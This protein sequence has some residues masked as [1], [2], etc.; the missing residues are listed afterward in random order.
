MSRKI[1]LIFVM[2]VA[3]FCIFVGG[4]ASKA[5]T[6][7]FN[8]TVNRDVVNKDPYSR[9]AVKKDADDRFYVT[10]TYFSHVATIK[11][12]SV[13][14]GDVNQSSKL[15]ELKSVYIN[16]TRKFFYGGCAVHP[17]SYYYMQST[18][19]SGGNDEINIKGRYTP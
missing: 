3:F 5:E 1:K 16:S 17:G 13:Y 7:D 19:H 10:P 4:Y 12:R 18:F 15:M 2:L 11:V 9:K 6:I 14:T 8:V